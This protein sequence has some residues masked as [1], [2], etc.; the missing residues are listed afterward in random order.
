MLEKLFG[1]VV[2][3]KILF[4]LLVNE[5]GYPSLLRRVFDVPLYS[6]Q[7]AIARLEDGGIVVAEL[8]GKTR[9]YQFNPRYPM[10]RELREFLSKSYSFLPREFKEKY[11]EAPVRRRPRRKGKP[12]KRVHDD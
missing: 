2:I 12:L 11:Y 3:E 9:V 5:K 1:N 8:Q 7:K 10:L 6:I 4:Y